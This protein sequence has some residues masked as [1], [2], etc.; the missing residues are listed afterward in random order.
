M[1]YE[2][3]LKNAGR[4]SNEKQVGFESLPAAYYFVVCWSQPYRKNRL[5]FLPSKMD[6]LLDAILMI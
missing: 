4:L 6:Y 1:T 2:F 5:Q 3:S